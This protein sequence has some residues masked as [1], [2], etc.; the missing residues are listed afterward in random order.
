MLCQTERGI[1][2]NPRLETNLASIWNILKYN[3]SAYNSPAIGADEA[4]VVCTIY[5]PID[6][7]LSSWSSRQNLHLRL[8]FSDQMAD[9]SQFRLS[10]TPFRAHGSPWAEHELSTHA[11]WIHPS[12]GCDDVDHVWWDEMVGDEWPAEILWKWVFCGV[13]CQH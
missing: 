5:Q 11:H 4:G 2:I 12:T 8:F 10:Q 13:T 3:I 1:F 6:K 9:V 7:C